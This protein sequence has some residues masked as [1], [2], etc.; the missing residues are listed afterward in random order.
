MLADRGLRRRIVVG[1]GITFALAAAAL[2]GTSS[3]LLF[4]AALAVLDPA[5]GAFVSLSQATLMDC[6]PGERERN[7]GR[8][9]LAGAVG[10][11]AGPL[12]LA[13]GAPWRGVFASCAALAACAVLA[14]RRQRLD[15]AAV[16][17]GFRAAWSVLRQREVLRWLVLLELEELGGDTFIGFLALYLVDVSDASP[18]AAALAVLAWTGAVLA[19]NL[20]LPSVLARVE[21]SRWLRLSAL[22]VALLFP[23]FQLAPGTV[24]KL[25]AVSAIGALVAGWYPISQARLY[26]ALPGRSGTAAAAATAASVLGVALPLALGALAGQVGLGSAFWLCLLAPLA[27]LVG[28]PRR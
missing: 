14:V 6:A 1:G 22:G 26:D 13:A 7:M 20:V 4:L 25:L 19:G 27:L 12:L 15:L 28:V 10:A 9:A 16:D 5:S 3:F 11:V 24:P 21:G 23:L 17:G 2:A 18:R 8:W